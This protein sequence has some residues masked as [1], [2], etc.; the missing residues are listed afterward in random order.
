MSPKASLPADGKMLTLTDKELKRY[1]VLRAIDA[2]LNPETRC[3]EVEISDELRKLHEGKE[4][5]GIFIPY[6]IGVDPQAAARAA[7][8][9]GRRFSQRTGLDT[10]ETGKG[11]ELVFVEPGSYLN[12][13]YNA[14]R[15][16]QAGA[17]VISGLSGNVAWPK[18]TGTATSSWV[19][20]NSGTDV[21][22]SNLTLAQVPSSPH[23]LQSS[24]S[25]SRQ[26]LAQSKSAAIGIEMVVRADL[27][28]GAALAID[29]AGLSGDGSGGSP[30]GIR[31]TSGVQPYTLASDAGNGGL[32]AWGDIVDM[33][34]LLENVN[35]DQLA[36]ASWITTP[37]VKAALK[38]TPRLGSTASLPIWDDDSTVDGLDAYGTNQL[39]SN[40][41]KGSGTNLSPLLLGVFY[42]V[43]IGVW[44]SGFE[45]IADPYRL[46]K[47]GMIE[48]TTFQMVDTAVLYP[49]AFVDCE[50]VQK[51]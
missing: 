33:Q 4:H 32:A 9:M 35:A 46:K 18:Q 47:Q 26:L 11:K 20:E 43:A 40:L 29:A 41:T 30:T 19:D 42:E 1:S 45:L 39:P 36:D 22:D 17:R 12:F 48:L 44:G 5:A 10:F 2:A 31:N 14:M 38:Q 16:K 8:S 25:F 21:A 13:L 7:V 28:R 50:A 51:K 37:G 3:F 15:L 27:A 34:E 49:Q 6:G 23:T 24:T